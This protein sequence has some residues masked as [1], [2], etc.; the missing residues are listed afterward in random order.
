[1]VKNLLSMS[2]VNIVR[3]LLQFLM[4]V[5]LTH[6]VTPSEFGLIAFSMPFI[7]FISLL[8]DLGLSSALVQRDALS[9]EDAGAA[10]TLMIGIGLLCAV[11]L[12]AASGPLAG[13][14]RMTDLPPVLAALSASVVLSIA[15]MAPRA[16][17]ERALRY[18]TIA[19]VEAGA[20]I[21]SAAACVVAAAAGLGIWA[22]IVN[23]V[24]VQ[25]IRLSAFVFLTWNEFLLNF[26]W[27]RVGSILTF[28]GWVLAAN[29]LNF[30]ARNVGN[31][32]IGA[33]LGSGALGLFA[34][35]YQ[36]MILPLMVLTW[37]ASGVLLA[38][39]SRLAR[40]ASD[41][42]RNEVICSLFSLT[43]MVTFPA[44]GYLTFGLNYP[45]ST[46]LSAS[47]SG[48][49]PLIAVLAP[50]GA[51][52]SIAS[53]VGSIMLSRGKARLQFWI[54]GANS[55]VLL[56]SFVFALAFGVLAIAQLYVAASIVS[57]VVTLAVGARSAGLT[58]TSLAGS[59]L[60]ACLA[61]GLGLAAALMATRADVASFDHWALASTLYVGVV[62]L[63]YVGLRQRLRNN[64]K[65]LLL[66]PQN[67]LQS[68]VA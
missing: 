30:A 19:C 13:A 42:Q 63:V 35:S 16:I 59:L 7:T 5:L 48:V 3:S 33:K 12:A 9:V 38:T 62:L 4:T 21:V 67:A 68:G 40:A 58:Y 41:D 1:M 39:L 34:L 24:L 11:V 20:A 43:A 61:T 36:F 25:M 52:Q 44:M 51:A 37:P 64:L 28:G 27:R 15:A 50:A 45:V 32:L 47:W 18:Q 2:G 29:I 65:S 49:V 46:F 23:Y 14:V 26:E 60:P 57:C 22:L 6:F 10:M 31:L 8:T 66:V 55:I 56:L 17:L 54:S 53:Y